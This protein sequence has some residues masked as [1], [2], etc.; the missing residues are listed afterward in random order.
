MNKFKIEEPNSNYFN[1][2]KGKQK[3]FLIVDSSNN[4]IGHV[5]LILLK[6][7]KE[8]GHSFVSIELIDSIFDDEYV[9]TSKFFKKFNLRSESNH[10]RIFHTR[11]NRNHNLT[12][13]EDFAEKCIIVSRIADSVVDILNK[14]GES[15]N[16]EEE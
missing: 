14:I 13:D 1:P 15:E 9:K 8:D 5:V 2:E 12:L 10:L 3:E 7:E 16:S 11:I 6:D 4:L